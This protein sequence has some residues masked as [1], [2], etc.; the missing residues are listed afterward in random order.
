M[1]DGIYSFHPASC[2]KCDHTHQLAWILALRPN[3]WRVP[4][5]STLCFSMF[6]NMGRPEYEA[7]VAEDTKSDSPNSSLEVQVSLATTRPWVSHSSGVTS[8]PRIDLVVKLFWHEWLSFN[9][10]L[11][12]LSLS[13]C[14]ALAALLVDI[15]LSW[16]LPV[17]AWGPAN[18]GYKV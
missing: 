13:G 8:E 9:S 16:Y 7:R 14:I 12:N 3:A 5:P 6:Q 11:K 10:R 17:A 2:R 4:S 15:V 1:P 18:I